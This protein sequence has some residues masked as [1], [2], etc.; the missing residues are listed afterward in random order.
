MPATSPFPTLVLLALFPAAASAAM[1]FR[2]VELPSVGDRPLETLS[3]ADVDKDG[4][5]DFYSGRFGSADW[6]ENLGGGLWQRHSISDS[7]DTDVGAAALDVDGDGWTDRVSGSFWYRNPGAAGGPFRTFRYGNLNFVHDLALGDIDGDG[8]SDVVSMGPREIFWLK[9]PADPVR[10]GEA[11]DWWER[12]TVVSGEAYASQHG[13]LSVGDIDGDGDADVARLDCWF[14]NPGPGG[15]NWTRRPGPEFGREG[16][17]GMTGRAL[18]LDMDGDGANDLLQTECDLKNGRVA[19][20]RNRG[21]RGLDWDMRLIKDS[22]DGQD[23]H[24]LL[25]ADFDGDGDADVVSQGN[26]NGAEPPKTYVWERQGASGTAWK[27][28]VVQ[29]GLFGHDAAAADFDGDGDI[30]IVSKTRVDSV[31]YILENQLVPSAAVRPG[32]APEA[33][34]APGIGPPYYRSPRGLS[35]ALGR[36]H[37]VRAPGLRPAA[38]ARDPGSP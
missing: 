2:A 20:F 12:D 14:E 27:E 21:G 34:A 9:R 31:I 33:S 30:D 3:A 32:H 28:H 19:W 7:T 10:A 6:H 16:P 5:M 15:G 29:E 13:G 38:A 18:V 23:F 26:A 37:G 36:R 17:W 1:R 8:R 25:V 4:D 24:T 22:T 11:G 35:D